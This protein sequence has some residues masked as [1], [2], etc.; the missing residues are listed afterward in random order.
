MGCAGPYSPPQKAM[1]TG[2]M[3]IAVSVDSVLIDTDSAVLPLAK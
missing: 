2:V 1:F 3:T